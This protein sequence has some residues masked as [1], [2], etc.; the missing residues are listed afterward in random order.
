[1]L[2]L[3]APKP[4]VKRYWYLL[5]PDQQFSTNE[6]YSDVL[7]ALRD[8][9]VPG[10]HASRIHFPE[11]N[12]FSAHREYLRL[13]RER[14]FFDI[15][16]TS[17]GTSWFFSFRFSILPLRLRLWE[18]ALLLAVAGGIW[19][20]HLAIFGEFWSMVVFP[21]NV[22]AF[23]YLLTVLAPMG[24]H[25]LDALILRTPALGPFYEIFLRRDTYYRE[26]T[27][28][29]Y[30]ELVNAIVRE[31]IRQTTGVEDLAELKIIEEFTPEG[32]SGWDIITSPFRNMW[33]HYIGKPWWQRTNR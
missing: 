29:M 25:D 9:K 28:L 10:M 17:F 18:V 2:S 22:L 5:L 27:R 6:F 23:L 1:M 14:L 16:S 31:K 19:S 33:D 20:A 8:A 11:G 32:P 15:C 24:L 12:L 3:F 26:D 21:C 4:K 13:R 30:F 7:T